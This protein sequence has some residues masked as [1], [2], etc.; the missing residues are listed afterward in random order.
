[1][2]ENRSRLRD[3]KGRVQEEQIATK[4]PSEREAGWTWKVGEGMEEA[5]GRGAGRAVGKFGALASLGVRQSRRG[6]SAT[7]YKRTHSVIEGDRIR[8]NALLPLK[9]RDMSFHLK[10]A[11]EGKEQREIRDRAL[12]T[13]ERPIS[14]RESDPQM[15]P[16]YLLDNMQFLKQR[17]RE[18]TRVGNYLGTHATVS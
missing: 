14:V 12:T 8:D 11:V 13:R 10:E 1:M 5:K 7:R 6:V 17:E 2:E 18:I 15:V 3:V 4:Q 9:S 16:E